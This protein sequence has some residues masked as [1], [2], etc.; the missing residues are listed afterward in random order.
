[1][2]MLK[3]FYMVASLVEQGLLTPQQ[4]IDVINRSAK[5]PPRGFIDT[6]AGHGLVVE[7]KG[8]PDD[9]SW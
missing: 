1:M 9:E 7:Q 2:E 3:R 6:L 5:Q 8:A 4:G